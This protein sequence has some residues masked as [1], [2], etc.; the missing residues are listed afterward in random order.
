MFPLPLWF[1]SLLTEKS[2]HQLPAV[3]VG[4]N[5]IKKMTYFK[6][7]VFFEGRVGLDDFL[8]CR[9]VV[10]LVGAG[11]SLGLFGPIMF[12]F[13]F[14]PDCSAVAGDGVG[15]DIGVL[16]PLDSLGFLVVGVVVV[17]GLPMK[18]D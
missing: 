9:V 3:S 5:T 12:V 16:R 11:V 13:W 10:F 18:F 7:C 1:N 8:F 2:N 15:V 4:R 6:E 14:D 17:E